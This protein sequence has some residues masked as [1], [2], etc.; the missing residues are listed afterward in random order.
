MKC[1]FEFEFKITIDINANVD[2]THYPSIRNALLRS[3]DAAETR[4]R[5]DVTIALS[6]KS[7]MEKPETVS[8]FDCQPE[9]KSLYANSV[10]CYFHA[11]GGQLQLTCAERRPHHATTRIHNAKGHTTQRRELTTA[12]F[13]SQAST[14]F[15]SETPVFPEPS[16]TAELN[17]SKATQKQNKA[18]ER[19]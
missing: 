6:G 13:P 2:I 1:E 15:S 8:S 11:D 12:G 16:L 10:G 14:S 9:L 17:R 18:H 19:K 3:C 7:P 4:A 5:M